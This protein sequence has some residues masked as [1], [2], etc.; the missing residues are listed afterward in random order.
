MTSK[1]KNKLKMIT[2]VIKEDSWK[3]PNFSCHLK[4]STDEQLKVKEDYIRTSWVIKNYKE[5]YVRHLIDNLQ[6]NRYNC[7]KLNVR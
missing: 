3:K 2:E 4:N 1:T 5:D 6:R 7:L